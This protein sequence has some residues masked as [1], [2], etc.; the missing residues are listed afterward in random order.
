MRFLL[1]YSSA[2]LRTRTLSTAKYADGT[3]SVI[4]LDIVQ[5]Q[6]R[7]QKQPFNN[8]LDSPRSVWVHHT[9]PM[10]LNAMNQ[11]FVKIDSG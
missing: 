11:M 6:T 10:G 4:C 9:T 5:G 8:L 1:N 3:I 7:P 2:F